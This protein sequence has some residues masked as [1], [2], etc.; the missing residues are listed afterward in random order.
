MNGSELSYPS[1]ELPDVTKS[2]ELAYVARSVFETPK[3]YESTQVKSYGVVPG[4]SSVGYDNDHSP[5][6]FFIIRRALDTGLYILEWSRS[7]FT[8][9]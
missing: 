6:A 9:A 3:E 2:L 7:A 1:F 8:N 4:F 5:F